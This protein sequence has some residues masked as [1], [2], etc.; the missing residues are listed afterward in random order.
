ML[1]SEGGPGRLGLHSPA[2]KEQAPRASQEQD[3]ASAFRWDGGK[4]WGVCSGQPWE[5]LQG[6][7]PPPLPVCLPRDF[8]LGLRLQISLLNHSLGG[9]YVRKALAR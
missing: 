6:L 2:L 3:G 8:L 4:S 7:T 9:S 1:S 5:L